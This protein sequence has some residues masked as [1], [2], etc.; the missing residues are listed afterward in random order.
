MHKIQLL[1]MHFPA[2]HVAWYKSANFNL[3]KKI[4][5]LHITLRFAYVHIS[6][7]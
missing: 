2:H 7:K 6:S 4:S 3:V 1:V 5:K